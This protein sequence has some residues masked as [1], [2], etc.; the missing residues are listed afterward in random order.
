[1]RRSPRSVGGRDIQSFRF[2][3]TGK[4][5]EQK[6]VVFDDSIG[7]DQWA[8][9]LAECRGHILCELP[10]VNAVLVLVDDDEI[11]DVQALASSRSGVVRV[12]DD[13]DIELAHELGKVSWSPRFREDIPWGVKR[14]N[15][16][17]ANQ[18]GAGVNVGILDTGI[19]QRH[20]DL[21]RNVKGGYSAIPGIESASDDNGHGTHVAG[22]IGALRNGLGVLGVAPKVNIYAVKVLNDKGSGKLSNLIDGI[23]WC[24]EKEIRVVNM[25]LSSSVENQTFRDM[26]QNARKAGITMVCAAGNRGPGSNSVGYP[27]RYVE[28]IAVA[29]IDQNDKIADFSSRGRE[30]TLSAPGVDILSTWP[31]RKYRKSTGTSMAAP[32]VTGTVALLLEADPGLSPSEIKSILQASA[33]RLDGVNQDEQGAGV[34]N[35]AQALSR[36]SKKR[37]RGASVMGVAT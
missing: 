2:S 13:I 4:R 20:P 19:D 6:I 36:I 27:A 8:E 3:A 16:G 21:S 34:L 14:V 7:R 37:T 11:A 26:V 5:R 10:L 9:I 12:E 15:I 35:V 30:V 32:H 28:S 33:D 23:G 25:S 17:D 31:G 22:T 29:A 1:M 18:T 24:V